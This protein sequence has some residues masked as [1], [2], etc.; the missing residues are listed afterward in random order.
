MSCE[1][2]GYRREHT[3]GVLRGVPQS[4][5]E[6]GQA[7]DALE[8]AHLFEWPVCRGMRMV[9]ALLR[10]SSSDSGHLYVIVIGRAHCTHGGGNLVYPRFLERSWRIGM[11]EYVR[12]QYSAQG[13][14]EAAPHFEVWDEARCRCPMYDAFCAFA[15]VLSISRICEP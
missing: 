6:E 9:Q 13:V 2:D 8:K 3:N 14:R 15:Y 7:I 10:C 11:G 4:K 12:S 5:V 1:L